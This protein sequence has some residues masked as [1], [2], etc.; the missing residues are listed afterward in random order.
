MKKVL[1]FIIIFII[2]FIPIFNKTSYYTYAGTSLIQQGEKEKNYLNELEIIQ[3]QVYILS[4]NILQFIIDKSDESYKNQILKDAEFIKT[5]IRQLRVELS[6]YHQ[7]K[8]GNVEKNPV[9]LALLNSLNYSSMAL[10]YLVCLLNEEIISDQ[11][12]CLQGYYFS[13]YQADQTLSWLK[14]QIK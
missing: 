12:E 5:Q 3:K 11:N 13:K 8:S 6:A 9:S 10:S 4:S 2:L 1:T 7:T 14:T